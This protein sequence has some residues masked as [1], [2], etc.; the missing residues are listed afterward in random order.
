MLATTADELLAV[1]RDDVDDASTYSA[2]NDDVCLWKD[3]EIYRYMTA[4]CDM[5]AK[6]TEALTK[7]V[8]LAYTEGVS[9]VTLPRYVLKIREAHDVTNNCGL[10]QLNANEAAGGDSSDYGRISTFN[11]LFDTATGHVRHFI[12]DYEK[13]NLRLVPIPNADGV[14]EIQCTVTLQAPMVSGMPLPFE[15]TEDQLLLLEFMKYLAYRKQDVETEDLTRSAKAKKAY[16]DGVEERKT[17]LRT[18]RR[19]PGVVRMETW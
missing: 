13:K 17:Q 5:L 6:D 10:D 2:D 7:I 14:L 11:P 1:F 19:T 4:A 3:R 12:R 15:D 8:R 16:D 9:I 18:Y